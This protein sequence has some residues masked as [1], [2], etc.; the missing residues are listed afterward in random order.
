MAAHSYRVGCLTGCGTAPEL[1][2]E[3]SRALQ[4]AARLHGFR[5]EEVHAPVGADAVQRHGQAVSHAAR[6]AFLSADAVLVADDDDAAFAELT[7]ELD[8]RAR[9]TRL[10]FGARADAVLLAPL[11]DDASA[12]TARRAFSLAAARRMRLTVV[13]GDPAWEDVVR[14]AEEHNFGVRVEWLD[15]DTAVRSAAFRA[16]S[17][18]VVLADAAMG[19]TL[20]ALVGATAVPARVAA[21]GLLAEHGPSV[22]LPLDGDPS[23]DAGHGVANPSSMLLAAAMMLGDG[24]GQRSAGDTLVGALAGALG[25]RVS[26][27]DRL[28]L[29]LAATTREFTDSVLAGFQNH[30]VNAEFHPGVLAQ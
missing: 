26:T 11:G 12:W 24:L 6:A 4:A 1:M 19:E 9:Q 3:A 17:L 20:S 23:A 25:G 29:G 27:V 10:L 8:L 21:L 15:R 22:F 28:R 5:L 2:A 7:Q 30:H 14:T 18:D 16:E 13:A